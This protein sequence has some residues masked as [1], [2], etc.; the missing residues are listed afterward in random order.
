MLKKRQET[1]SDCDSYAC[2]NMHMKM[3]MQ[4]KEYVVTI[5]YPLRVIVLNTLYRQFLVFEF[6]SGRILRAMLPRKKKRVEHP[7][8]RVTVLVVHCTEPEFFK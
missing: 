3:C 4:R 1:N 6:V 2:K 5:A 7:C 8:V